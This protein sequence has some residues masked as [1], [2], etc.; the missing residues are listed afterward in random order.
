MLLL[1]YTVP[2]HDFYL[3]TDVSQ[4]VKGADL[5]QCDEEDVKHPL[6]YTSKTLAWSRYAYC[7]MKREF[8]VVAFF[9]IYFQNCT[10]GL[11]AWILTDDAALTQ[12]SNF[13]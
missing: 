13:K 8:Y 10:H 12:L 1:H 5:Y 7:T 6:A 3:A 4:Y 11:K 9:M 2:G